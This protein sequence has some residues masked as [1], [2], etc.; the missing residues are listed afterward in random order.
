MA[1][2]MSP[3]KELT[4]EQIGKF[5]ELLAAGLRKAGI[6]SEP[7]QQAIEKQGKAIAAE[8]L[9]VVRRFVDAMRDFIT[10]LVTVNRSRG[11]RAALEATG[12]TIY[13]DDDVVEAMPRGEGAEGETKL[14]FF[15][16]GKS[17]KDDPLEDEF[18]LRG[19]R[20]ATPYELAAANEDDPAFADNNPNA[21]HWKDASGKWCYAAFY[22]WNGERKVRVYRSDFEWGDRW[23]FAGVCKS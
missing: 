8:F 7:A 4:T 22:H 3:S 19:L 12:R 2:T 11:P 13:A 9:A 17:I 5:Q 21:T 10:R 23:L 15:K 14:V 16:V 18:E 20:P 6:Q 1:T